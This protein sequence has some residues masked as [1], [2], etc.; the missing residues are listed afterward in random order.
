MKHKKKEHSDANEMRRRRAGVALR[1]YM[2]EVGVDEPGDSLV[3]LFTDLRHWCN[4]RE[5]NRTFDEAIERSRD[6]FEVESTER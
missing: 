5:L 4:G 3:D 2:K 1:A 6:H